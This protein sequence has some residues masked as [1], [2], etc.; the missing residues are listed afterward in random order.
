MMR[1]TTLL[2][3]ILGTLGSLAAANSSGS[4][5]GLS[6]RQQCLP[7]ALVLGVTLMV[8]LTRGGKPARAVAGQREQ[9][10]GADEPKRGDVMSQL[11]QE[12]DVL[13]P[14]KAREWLDTFLIEQQ[15]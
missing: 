11:L 3:L 12:N 7:A 8:A 4:L 10:R 9:E 2:S 13:P 1:S 6:A 15:K 5:F 14:E